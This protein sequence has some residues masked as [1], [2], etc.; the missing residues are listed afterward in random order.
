MKTTTKK[1][2]NHGNYPLAT[3]TAAVTPLPFRVKH[4]ALKKT[5][6]RSNQVVT[7]VKQQRTP[8]S[9]EEANRILNDQGFTKGLIESINRSNDVFP[10]RYWVIDNSGSMATADGHRIHESNDHSI[11]FWNCTRWAEIQDTVS[12]HARMAAALRSPTSFRLLNP[13]CGKEMFGIAEDGP[14]RIPEDLDTALRTL[15]EVSPIGVTPLSERVQEIG[16]TVRSMRDQLI[17]NGHKAVIVLATD[18]LPSDRY[19]KSTMVERR[20]FQQA[21]RS[22]EG[23]PVWVVIR[24]C[25]DDDDIV[26]FYNNIDNELELSLDVLDDFVAEAQEVYEHNKWLNY[27]L[28][29]HRMREMGFYHKLFDLIDERALT[30][31]ELR[32]FFYLLYGADALDGL[33]DP[34]VHWDGFR[35]HIARL[36]RDAGLRYNPIKKRLT[37]C[38]DIRQLDREF[39]DTFNCFSFF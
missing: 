35:D 24:L 1:H 32:D 8:E 36:T 5:E 39:G 14:E 23:L 4:E 18:G 15:R 38:I 12:Y 3:A 17:A 21:L 11:R 19:G 9:I 7:T 30:R 26:D 33:P 22:L 2:F 34:H 25:T 20:I 37:P 16:V 29:L 27:A 10:Q 31:D 13:T 28:P 6:K